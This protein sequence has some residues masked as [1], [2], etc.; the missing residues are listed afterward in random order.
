MNWHCDGTKPIIVNYS[1]E[2]DGG[3]TWFGQDYLPV[4]QARYGNRCFPNAM[5]WCSG[6]GFIGFN[7]LSHGI[8]DK[9]WLTDS[10]A[11][12]IDMIAQTIKTNDLQDRVQAFTASDLSQWPAIAPL[13]LVVANPPHYLRCPGD[14][15]Y[16]RLAVDQ[17]WQAHQDFYQQIGRFLAP[18]GV[19]LMQEN[20]AGSIHGADDFRSM[21]E[22][23]G[24][25]ISAV[26]PSE[27]FWFQPGPW[28]QIYYMEIRR[29]KT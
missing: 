8:C 22:R 15:N 27:Q 9:L 14:S 6:P 2:M 26:W 29:K 17:D 21:I 20:Q 28:A 25:E 10:W 11:P 1:S 3:G 16:Q 24:L 18:H 19:V 4:I 23:G 5:E 13:D 12:C 7:L